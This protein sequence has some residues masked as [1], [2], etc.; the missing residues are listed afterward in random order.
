MD[1]VSA[2]QVVKVISFLSLLKRSRSCLIVLC[3]YHISQSARPS[4]AQLVLLLAK[5]RILPFMFSPAVTV[6]L[7]H[8]VETAVFPEFVMEYHIWGLYKTSCSVADWL[9]QWPLWDSS[10]FIR[11]IM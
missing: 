5:H 4:A 10:R 9:D 11:M 8:L 7:T 2:C 3:L 1:T 6:W